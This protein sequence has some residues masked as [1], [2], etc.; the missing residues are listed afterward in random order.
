M[1]LIIGYGNPLRSDDAVGH[2]ITGM[3]EQRQMRGDVQIMTVYQL[4]PELVETLRDAQQVIF[5]DA[6]TGKKPGV[7]VRESVQPEVS[8]GAFTHHVSPSTLLGA[9]Y[10]LYGTC[11]EALL[12]SVTGSNFGYGETLSPYVKLAVPLVLIAVEEIIRQSA[13]NQ[14]QRSILACGTTR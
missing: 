14:A 2:H 4:T 3:L 8:T 6:R 12:F 9:A 11:P 10:E 5:I 13:E 1:I 7:I